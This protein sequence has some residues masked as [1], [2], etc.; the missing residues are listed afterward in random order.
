MNRDGAKDSPIDHTCNFIL[1]ETSPGYLSGAYVC[2]QC[3][4]TIT[5]KQFLENDVSSSVYRAPSHSQ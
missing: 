5:Q 3:G 4:N 1:E 2:K